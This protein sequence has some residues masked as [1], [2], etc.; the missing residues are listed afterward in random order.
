MRLF[1]C[2]GG[3]LPAM[4]HHATKLRQLVRDRRVRPERLCL[5][6]HQARFLERRVTCGAAVSYA[7]LRHPDLLQTALKTAAQRIGVAAPPNQS[8]VLFLVPEPLPK[9]ILP[10]DDR[11]GN[12]EHRTQRA[13]G[14]RG[15]AEQILP[16]RTDSLRE[17][18]L[19]PLISGR[20]R[21]SRRTNRGR[22]RTSRSA[23]GSRLAPETRT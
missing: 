3:A 7:Q 20:S 8:H 12:Q 10:G 4:A 2:R 18:H 11:E 22:G 16:G 17:A 23:S 9:I 6:I 15:V 19:S 5:H 14:A 21:A 13:E 1:N